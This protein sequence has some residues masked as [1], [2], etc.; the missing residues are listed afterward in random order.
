M[1]TNA[2]AA[3]EVP[4]RIRCKVA[5]KTDVDNEGRKII[6]STKCPSKEIQEHVFE[7]MLLFMS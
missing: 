5:L 6:F 2:T 7:S 4:S 3:A 1:A